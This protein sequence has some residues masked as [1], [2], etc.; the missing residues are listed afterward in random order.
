MP[1]TPIDPSEVP[2]PSA[3]P[4]FPTNPEEAA[5]WLANPAIKQCFAISERDIKPAGQ[6]ARG[7]A[8]VVM[9]MFPSWR[10]H[11]AKAEADAAA[12]GRS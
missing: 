6:W 4:K 5:A 2:P 9:M 1:D 12:Q 7:R 11:R 10:D 3:L 8:H